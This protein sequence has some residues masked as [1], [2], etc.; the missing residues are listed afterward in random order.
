M[1]R[2]GASPTNSD[3]HQSVFVSNKRPLP[4]STNS[5]PIAKKSHSTIQPVLF[6][7][8]S[9]IGS[10]E[11]D[12]AKK[13]ITA[14]LK[15]LEIEIDR[16]QITLGRNVLVHPKNV[17]A[18]NKLLG[19]VKLFGSAKSID[20]SQRENP[21]SLILKG[22]RY[23]DAQLYLESGELSNYGVIEIFAFKSRIEG[24]EPK[25]VKIVFNNFEERKQV[26]VKR[27][28]VLDYFAYYLEEVGAQPKQCRK[29]KK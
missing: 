26:L 12:S 21:P 22:I 15:K 14:E 3:E 24:R 11:H 10:L 23:K 25:I 1:E 8:P 13:A 6:V 20:F 19:Q 7:A 16:V 4:P 28:I 29:C 18:K 9:I 17:D 27:F 2:D 5:S